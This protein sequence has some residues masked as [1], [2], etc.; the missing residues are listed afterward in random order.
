M[1]LLLATGL[2][3]FSVQASYL[4]KLTQQFDDHLQ[5]TQFKTKFSKT[6]ENESHENAH[7]ATFVKALRKYEKHNA[8]ENVSYKM[9]VNQFSDLTSEQFR[10]QYLMTRP[11][12]LR[13][14]LKNN[15]KNNGDALPYPE[16]EWELECPQRFEGAEIPAEFENHLDWRDA[17][18]NPAKLVGVTAI[19]NQASCGSC[20]VFSANAAMESA[21]CLKGIHDCAGFIGLSEQQVL[22]C[23]T[24]DQDAGEERTWYVSNGCRGGWQSNVYQHVYRAGGITCGHMGPYMSGNATYTYPDNK[25]N[26]G[27]CPYN[28]ETQYDWIQATSHGYVDKNICGTTNKGGS[29]DPI[30]M[31]QAV[32]SKGAL[33]VG[34]YVGDNFRDVVEGIYTPEDDNDGDCPTI[35][36]TGINHAMNAVGYGVSDDGQEYWIIRNSWGETFAQGGYVKVARGVNACGIEGNVSYADMSGEVDDDDDLKSMCYRQ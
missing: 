22:D 2:A 4:P 27:E 29:K 35:E 17:T 18:K 15:G 16:E 20:Y 32:Y 28:W 5:W 26:V 30:A 33:A 11:K 25:F 23:A 13:P 10:N 8:R 1:K 36:Q 9:G 14:L 31:K 12:K 19:K 21:L 7:F 3:A 24:Y 6:Y 34:M